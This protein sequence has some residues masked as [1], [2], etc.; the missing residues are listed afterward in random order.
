MCSQEGFNNVYTSDIR[1]SLQ[2]EL[3]EITNKTSETSD[4]Q[5]GSKMKDDQCEF[6]S[7]T[8]LTQSQSTS[9]FKVVAEQFWESQ[10][11]YKNV[12]QFKNC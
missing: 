11:K 8:L 2:T 9:T 4:R 1:M 10:Q 6:T 7:K 12:L 5:G 3:T